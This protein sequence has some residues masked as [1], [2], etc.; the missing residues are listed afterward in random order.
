VSLKRLFWSFIYLLS[1]SF[2][3]SNPIPRSLNVAV[4]SN[5]SRAIDVINHAYELKYP[6]VKIKKIVGSTGQLVAQIEHGAPNDILLA[7]DSLYVDLLIRNKRVDSNNVYVFAHG[8]LVLWSKDLGLDL[9]DLK[10]SLLDKKVTRIAIANPNTAPFGRAAQEVIKNLALRDELNSK[11]VI[12][13]TVAQAAQF[14]ESSNAQL[15]FIALSSILALPIQAQGKWLV[16]SPK[17]YAPL[18]Q[19]AVVLQNRNVSMDAY[20]YTLFLSSLKA[21]KI[22]ADYGYIK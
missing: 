16:I 4:A 1:N 11:L 14:V 17:L 10:T 18:E 20:N 15:G 3:F 22:L 7:A 9:L 19:T 21:Q 6:D 5:L 2:V 12:A 13:E 8:V